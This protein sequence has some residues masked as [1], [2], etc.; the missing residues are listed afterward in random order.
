M[1]YELAEQLG[2][3]AG[4]TGS[5][6]RPAAAPAWSACG[7]R[8]TSS[9]RIGWMPPRPAAA[10]GVGA[11]RGLRADRPR[12][13]AGHREGARRGRTRTTIADGLRVPRAI[14]D[15]LILRA[16][17][18]ERRHGARRHDRDGRRHA[19]IG[20]P[21]ASAPR[22]KAARRSRRQQLVADGRSSRR[23]GRAVQHRRRA[24]VPRSDR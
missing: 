23:V 1:A 11:G 7:R 18:R 19:E 6:I 10:D 24:E 2:L 9:K 3:A 14:G 12:V 20:A 15:F 17:P 5:S 16:D 22:P 4:R 21:K 8:S 13:R